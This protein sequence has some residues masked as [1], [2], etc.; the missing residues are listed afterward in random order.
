ML[1]ELARREILLSSYF[2]RDYRPVRRLSSSA[3]SHRT[4][5]VVDPSA[6]T[7]AFLVSRVTKTVWRLYC[8]LCYSGTQVFSSDLDSNLTA[9]TKAYYPILVDIN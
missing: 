5:F 3:F 6:A 7:E 8:S 1:V 2:S 9:L 4:V